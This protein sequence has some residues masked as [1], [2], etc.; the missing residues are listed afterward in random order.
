MG[1]RSF[2]EKK[3]LGCYRIYVRVDWNIPLENGMGVEGSLKLTRSFPLL[4]KLREQ[5][6]II[7]LL[8]H[9]GRP[10]GREKA[11]ST[12]PLA[13]IAS[14]HSDL[15]MTYLDVNLN[16]PAGRMQFA[17]DVDRFQPGDIVL[18]ENVRFQKGEDTC[19][20]GLVETYASHAD[21]FINNAF[22]SCHRE[23]ATVTGLANAMPSFA[24]PA[25]EEEINALAPLLKRPKKPYVAIIGGAKLSTKLPVI[26]ALL[27]KADKVLIGGAMAHP[28]FA[29][30]KLP[31]GKSLIEKE[32]VA[33]AKKLL[34]EK[35]VVIPEDVV[36]AKKVAIGQRPRAS[37][38]KQ[39]QSSDVIVD[40]GP[41]TMCAWSALIAGAKTVVW[42][43]PVGV[44]EIPAF[45]HGSLV[46][47]SCIASHARRNM[48]GVAGGGDTIPVVARTGMREWFDFVSTGGGAMLEFLAKGGKLP[49]LRAL[50]GRQEHTL[51]SRHAHTPEQGMSCAPNLPLSTRKKKS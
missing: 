4:K 27:K 8:T 7:F 34:R 11:L 47:G 6:A 13:A 21:A 28:F 38:F 29:A 18:L 2:P 37:S 19:D 15:D 17:K 32:A 16:T 26:Q 1:L 50:E 9:R 25:L 35:K 3:D 45:A 46:I 39:I 31:I 42:N 44:T 51:P 5:G 33:I 10:K 24:G 43:G 36:V 20:A 12:E 48:Y 22:A 49:G 14:A 30:K 41:K 23:H 40:V